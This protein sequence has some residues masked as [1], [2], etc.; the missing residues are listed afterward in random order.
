MGD[1]RRKTDQTIHTNAVLPQARPDPRSGPHFVK[2]A[3]AAL[4]AAFADGKRT[5][6]AKQVGVEPVGTDKTANHRS[7]GGRL[8]IPTG[9][10]VGLDLAATLRTTPHACVSFP[11]E[12]KQT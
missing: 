7:V 6:V 4:R 12:E 1:G 9:A 8:A 10:K 5:P 3:G 2:V 11:E